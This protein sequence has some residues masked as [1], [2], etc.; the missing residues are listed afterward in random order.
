MGDGNPSFYR[1][2]A[3]KHPKVYATRCFRC[4]DFVVR[5]G[6]SV[7]H[8]D[9]VHRQGAERTSHSLEHVLISAGG[10]L[11]WSVGT[12]VKEADWHREGQT[13]IF[14]LFDWNAFF[15]RLPL[16][17]KVQNKCDGGE[18]KQAIRALGDWVRP[19]KGH[20]FYQSGRSKIEA[21]AV[22]LIW[23]KH[24]VDCRA[25]DGKHR[26]SCWCGTP[27]ANLIVDFLNQGL[28]SFVWQLLKLPSE[29]QVLSAHEE[30][31]SVGYYWN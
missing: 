7:W 18:E 19:Y 17:R 6:R 23:R 20:H 31:E 1:K 28:Q 5:L 25:G 13:T 10:N 16:L 22:E 3:S 11:A 24:P 21:S 15:L 30:Q 29:M 9:A 2:P 4:C 14:G 12:E 8:A 27:A 26:V